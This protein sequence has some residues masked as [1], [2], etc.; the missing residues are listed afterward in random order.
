M[1]APLEIG[2]R[3][4]TFIH[5]GAHLMILG[6]DGASG[7]VGRVLKKAADDGYPYRSRSGNDALI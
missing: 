6:G 2:G 5:V 3:H 7:F 4:E 1:D